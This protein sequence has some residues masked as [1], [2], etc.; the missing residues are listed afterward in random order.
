MFNNLP[1]SAQ[2][3]VVSYIGVRR[4][5]G[6]SGL[7]LPILLGPVGWLVFGIDIQDNMSSSS[8]EGIL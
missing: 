8:V 7:M 3:L 6:I 2:P 4:A 1:D 5:V